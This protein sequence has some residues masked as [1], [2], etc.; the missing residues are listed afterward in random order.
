MRAHINLTFGTTTGQAYNLRVP[1]ALDTTNVSLVRDSMDNVI[2]ANAIDTGGR[3]ELETR[4][5]A[6]LFRVYEESFDVA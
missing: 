5:A 1:N 4:R 3:G 6:T 2:G